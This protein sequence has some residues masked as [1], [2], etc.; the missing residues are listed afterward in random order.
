MSKEVRNTN[1]LP[2]PATSVPTAPIRIYREWTKF[3][4]VSAAV[5]VDADDWR[6]S[7][8]R[9]HGVEIDGTVTVANENQ[10]QASTD[11]NPRYARIGSDYAPLGGDI[12]LLNIVGVGANNCTLMLETATG[13]LKI[14]CDGFTSEFHVEFLVEAFEIKSAPERTI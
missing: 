1:E 7:I 3:T 9:F 2:S 10:W 6:G 4:Q 12:D 8:I 11:I 13:K 5:V 14:R